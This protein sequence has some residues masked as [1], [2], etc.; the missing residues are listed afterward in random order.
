M[1]QIFAR[2]SEETVS[3]IPENFKVTFKLADDGFNAN[4]AAGS[5][6]SMLLLCIL[7]CTFRGGGERGAGGLCLI[8]FQTRWHEQRTIQWGHWTVLKEP[9]I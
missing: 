6:I 1:R 2:Y 8:S 7:C 9:V 5:S 4:T 3:R